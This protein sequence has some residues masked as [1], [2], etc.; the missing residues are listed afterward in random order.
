M[1]EGRALTLTAF[2]TLLLVGLMMG[3]NHVAA[4]VAFGSGLDVATAVAVRSG[5]T[6]MV[7]GLLIV[8]ARVPLMG[9]NARQRKSLLLIGVLIGLQSQCLYSSVARLPVALA[10]LAFNTYPLFTALWDRLI[11]GH[12]PSKAMVGAMPVI[13]IG[14][15]LALDVLGAASGLGAGTQWAQMGAGVAFALAAAASFGLAL[16]VTQHETQGLDGRWRTLFNMSTACV[17]ALAV[18]AWH[19]APQWPGSPMGWLG[20]AALSFLYGTAFTIMFTVLP[21]LGAASYSAIMNVEPIFALVLAWGLLDQAIAPS[22][23]LGAM[24]VVGAVIWLGLR[25]AG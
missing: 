1:S 2:L 6:A 21:R 8:L 15:G 20:L 18:V 5:V 9:L 22:Q 17:I 25:K 19:G 12:A 10:L 23:V 4:R 3:A 16:I 14:L 7:V 24:L 13:L 11:Y